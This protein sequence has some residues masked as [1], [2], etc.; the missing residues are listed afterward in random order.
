MFSKKSRVPF[1]LTV[2]PLHF[3]KPVP[4]VDGKTLFAT[5]LQ[6]RG[7]LM[8]YDRRTQRFSPYLSGISAQ[9]V[10]FSKDGAWMTYVTFPQGELWRC[11]ADGSEPLQLTFPPMIAHDPHWSPNGKQI[12]YSGLLAGGQWQLY[13]VAIDVSLA[14]V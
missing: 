6:S 9:G 7:E 2:G 1:Q 12:V 10:S 5:G 4:S 13:T 11:R 8:R 14:R 3:A